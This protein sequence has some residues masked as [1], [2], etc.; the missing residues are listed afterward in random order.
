M[1]VESLVWSDDQAKLS[2][3]AALDYKINK[4]QD[5]RVIHHC[6][7][8]CHVWGYRLELEVGFICQIFNSLNI[9]SYQ[10]EK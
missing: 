8:V 2:I 10:I 7:C 1:Q 5:E 3:H 9:C 6:C 4:L